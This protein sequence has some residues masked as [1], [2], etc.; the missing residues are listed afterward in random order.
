MPCS[1]AWG[2]EVGSLGLSFF[3]AEYSSQRAIRTV[4]PRKA[5]AISSLN[6]LSRLKNVGNTLRIRRQFRSD[7]DQYEKYCP[8]HADSHR[9]F[10]WATIALSQ[11]APPFAPVHQV[12]DNYF[13]HEIRDPYRYMEKGTSEATEWIRAQGT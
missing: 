4:A 3:S 13:G 5:A 1:F 9:I 6:R 11:S 2:R 10:L 12:I 8:W 7:V